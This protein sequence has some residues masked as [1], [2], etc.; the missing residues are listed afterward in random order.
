MRE[1]ARSTT[2]SHSMLLAGTVTGSTAMRDPETAFI[3]EVADGAGLLCDLAAHGIERVLPTGRR[4][5][6]ENLTSVWQMH[7]GPAG[8]IF[9]VAIAEFNQSRILIPAHPPQ[10]LQSPHCALRGRPISVMRRKQKRSATRADPTQLSQRRTPI[11]APR[12]LHQA[13]EHEQCATE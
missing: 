6:V 9:E 1:D 4:E 5:I 7:E 11:L 8:V 13:I 10:G 2:V 12:D 3:G